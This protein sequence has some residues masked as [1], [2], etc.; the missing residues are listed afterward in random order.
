MFL[1]I[2]YFWTPLISFCPRAPVICVLDCLMSYRSLRLCSGF[3]FASL[4]IDSI[5]VFS[6]LLIYHL[7]CLVS[8][9]WCS[10]SVLL[11]EYWQYTRGNYMTEFLFAHLL[12]ISALHCLFATVWKSN[13]VIFLFQF[14]SW[15]ICR[16]EFLW[17]E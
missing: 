2:S 15:L 17:E 5:A 16:S 12:G 1:Q 10:L 13:F 6:V 8:C 9:F 14:S 4:W 11:P 3:L 7:Q